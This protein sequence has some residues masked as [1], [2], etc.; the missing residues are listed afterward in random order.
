MDTQCYSCG[1]LGRK[2]AECWSKQGSTTK[3]EAKGKDG[4]K[5]KH[6]EK[7]GKHSP[8]KGTGRKGFHDLGQE[9]GADQGRQE[10]E[11]WKEPEPEIKSFELKAL[12]L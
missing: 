3:K 9:G 6:P 12:D 7:N 10:E 2:A 4:K 8:G 11:A 5:G 1:G